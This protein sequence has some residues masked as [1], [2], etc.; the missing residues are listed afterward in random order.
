MLSWFAPRNC[1]KKYHDGEVKYFK[2]P[3]SAEG[4]EAAVL[5]YHSWLHHRKQTRPLGPE[6]QH[7]IQTLRQCLEWYGRFGTPESDED[8]YAEITKLIANLEASSESDEPLPPVS[9]CL[10]D[11]VNLPEKEL[12]FKFCGNGIVG[13]NDVRPAD[14]AAFD[15]RFGSWDGHCRAS[16]KN[17]S[18]NLMS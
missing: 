13:P 9:D 1:W 6:Y 2:Q 16:G 10:P 14:T 7:H 4:Y 11:G 3:N 8:L 18:G 17:E 5:E 15:H 12:I